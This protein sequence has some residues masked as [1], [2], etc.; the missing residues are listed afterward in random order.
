MRGKINGSTQ[1]RVFPRVSEQNEARA[2]Q[3]FGDNQDQRRQTGISHA[4][5]GN[6]R[7]AQMA[8]NS[9]A[10]LSYSGAGAMR[11]LDDGRDGGRVG[12]HGPVA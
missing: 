1:K 7:Y 8:R 11:K 4:T 3:S 10:K 2:Q 9:T 12:D 5:L 6:A